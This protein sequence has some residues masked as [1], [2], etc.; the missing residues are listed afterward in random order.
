[1]EFK[2]FKN[3]GHELGLTSM[4]ASRINEYILVYGGSNFPDGTP[5]YG[6]RKVY[7]DMYLYDL[8][9]NLVSKQKGI[10]KPD[11]SIV[12]SYLDKIYLIS[13]AG[14]TKIY[15]YTLDG[16]T[17]I[18]KEIFDLGFEIIGGFGGIYNEKIYFGKEYVYEFDLKSLEIK[19][20]AKFIGEVREQSVSFISNGKIY[21]F[22]GA[23]NICCL[24]SYIYEINKNEW[25]KISDTPTCL[26]GAASCKIDENNFLI[27]G[28]CNKE[29]F[30][31][32]VKSLGNIE[33]KKEYFS[34]KRE[35]FNWNTKVYIYNTEEDKFIV[36]SQGNI[37]NATCGS[38][39]LKIDNK[40]YLI[41][42]EMKPG[43]RTPQV[44]VG[45]LI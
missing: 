9:F 1:M 18:E 3:I 12:I 35:N 29:I 30:D 45:E 5:P 23:S 15:E 22:S 37:L 6:T 39:M 41:N 44:L 11:R 26:T 33:Y 36:L 24:D 4:L 8:E 14:N 27:T 43:H 2:F 32:A 7:D 21:L 10:I 25:R 38:S 42:G 28:G 13:G 31:V 34:K 20:L 40:V 19:E 17:I 16:T